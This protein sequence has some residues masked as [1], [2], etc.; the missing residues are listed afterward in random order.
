MISKMNDIPSVFSFPDHTKQIFAGTAGQEMQETTA[1]FL[2]G[3]VPPPL[4][5][6]TNLV[7]NRILY[8]ISITV[9]MYSIL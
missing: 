3:L 6:Y 9:A 4:Q 5:F 2:P 8:N 7:H 1:H